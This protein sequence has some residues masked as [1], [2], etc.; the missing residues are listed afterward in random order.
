MLLASPTG[1]TI[2]VAPGSHLH[3]LLTA[4]G[5][6]PAD[7]PA[8]RGVRLVTEA[9]LAAVESR[10]DAIPPL[11][12]RVEDLETTVSAHA[13]ELAPKPTPRVDALEEA[14]TALQTA[15]A[16]LTTQVVALAA[17]PGVQRR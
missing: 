9:E 5:Y 1:D 16:S 8:A 13:A 7:Q 3:K 10:L 6:Q 15:V 2:Q 4:K 17:L 12:P 14:V 11:E